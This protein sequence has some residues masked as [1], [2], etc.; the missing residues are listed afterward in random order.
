V[1]VP[2]TD[3]YTIIRKG[4]LA[5]NAVPIC[6]FAYMHNLYEENNPVDDCDEAAIRNEII[7]SV[8]Y[9]GGLTLRLHCG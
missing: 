2:D 9:A 6:L 5:A 3:S 8:R 7:I 4:I 1:I